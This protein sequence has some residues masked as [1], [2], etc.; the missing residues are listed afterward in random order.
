MKTKQE[1]AASLV[2]IFLIF[3][4][5]LI[6]ALLQWSAHASE[7]VI[8]CSAA[9]SCWLTEVWSKAYCRYGEDSQTPS[10]AFGLL[11]WGKNTTAID[12]W[13]RGLYITTTFH[14]EEMAKEI[15]QPNAVRPR[16]LKSTWI[17][18][19]KQLKIFLVCESSASEPFWGSWVMRWEQCSFCG[20]LYLL[21]GLPSCSGPNFQLLF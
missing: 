16:A 13:V 20:H 2:K 10:V 11:R 9:H 12:T 5:T 21:T 4:S 3:G 14:S 8:A 1:A 6:P 7:L 17:L 19:N 15:L 18:L